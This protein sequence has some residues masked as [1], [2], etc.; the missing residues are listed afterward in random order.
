M[1]GQH[2]ERGRSSPWLWWP[3]LWHPDGYLQAWW[4]MCL[5]A[6]LHKPLARGPCVLPEEATNVAQGL[7]DAGDGGGSL[8]DAA[9]KSWSFVKHQ[10][11]VSGQ[12]KIP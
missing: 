7:W 3:L 5:A 8:R 9:R 1:W 12:G 2:G 10:G 11:R 6:C 4:P